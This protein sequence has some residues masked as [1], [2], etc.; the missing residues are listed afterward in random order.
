MKERAG[1]KPLKK[2][3]VLLWPQWV[4]GQLNPG[5]SLQKSEY[6]AWSV[7]RHTF[8]RNILGVE[9]AKTFL[10]LNSIHLCQLGKNQMNFILFLLFAFFFFLF[11]VCANK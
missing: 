6:T 9:V 3:K 10:N 2:D 7:P 8:P 11:D 4:E 5:C 1:V